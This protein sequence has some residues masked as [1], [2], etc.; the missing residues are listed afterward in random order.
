MLAPR[1][2]P[3]KRQ[4]PEP[5]K[6]RAFFLLSKQC[7]SD[8]FFGVSGESTMKNPRISVSLTPLEK[9]EVEEKAGLF[10]MSASEYCHWRIFGAD[11]GTLSPSATMQAQSSIG[12]AHSGADRMAEILGDDCEVCDPKVRDLL[13]EELTEM[14]V[15]MRKA[16]QGLMPPETQRG[17]YAGQAL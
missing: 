5:T 11:G 7:W 3:E 4:K 16:H 15:L 9:A 17:G 10:E 14:M 2:P 12:L 1:T 6:F 8:V 13:L